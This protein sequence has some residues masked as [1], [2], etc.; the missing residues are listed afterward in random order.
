LTIVSTAVCDT[1]GAPEELAEQFEVKQMALSVLEKVNRTLGHA[2]RPAMLSCMK[3]LSALFQSED[4]RKVIEAPGSNQ[5]T[6]A[7]AASIAL[8][9][10]SFVETLGTAV[11]AFV[12]GLVALSVTIVGSALNASQA[13]EDG[14]VHGFAN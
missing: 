1:L 12:P 9:M 13:S 8:C 10:A 6:A 5:N 14:N 7:F 11:A 2:N 4:I 3:A